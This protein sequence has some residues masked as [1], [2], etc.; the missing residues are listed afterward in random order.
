M[1]QLIECIPNFSEARRPEV[2]DQIVAAIESVSEVKMLDRSSDLDHNRT[3]LTFA[4]TPAGVEEAAFRAIKTASELI[5]LNQHTG[6]HPRIGATDVVPFVPLSD[7]SMEECVAIAQ[8]LGMRIGGE[9]SIPVYLYEAAATR[10]ERAN[11][12]NIRKG[13]YEGLKVEVE[14]DPNRKPDFGP[15]KLGAAGATVIGARNPL[16]AFNVYLT[17]EDVDIAKKIA[18]AVRQSS[19]GLR[20]VKGLGLLVDGR[21]QV[22]MNLTNFRETPIARVVEF[23]RREAQR[24]G[25]GIHHSELVGLIPQEALVDAAVWYTQLDQFDKEQILESRL[26]S[27]PAAAASDSA[28]NGFSFIEHLAAPTPTP[29]GG[30]AG[31]YAGAMGAGLVAMVAGLTI[32]KKKYAEVEAEMQAIRVMAESLRKELTQAVD[33]DA[34]SFEVLMVTFK[35]PKETDEQKLLRSAAIAQ[36]TLNAAHVPLHVAGDSVKVME[37]ALKCAKDAN[38]NAISDSMSGFAM[39]R[40]ALT[41]A[42][43]NVRININSLEDKSLG[44]KM[45]RELAELEE[46]ADELEKEIRAV[47]KSRGGI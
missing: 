34:S 13:Q 38:L 22:S 45:L 2:I 24:Y 1:T 10:P 19:G 47:M 12:E 14:K 40:A 25:V 3:V 15:A 20:Y 33:D 37:L 44:D 35:M 9:L 30:S 18:K 7:V 23:I 39:A 43:Y 31:A 11:L 27:T 46:R 8:R 42:G 32:G 36:A 21:A 26:F 5:D 28:D 6:A 17:T 4:G 29:G 41:A 16:I